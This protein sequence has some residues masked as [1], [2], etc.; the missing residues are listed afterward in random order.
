MLSAEKLYDQIKAEHNRGSYVE[1]AD[2]AKMGVEVAPEDARLWEFL[3]IACHALRNFPK[4][5]AA[6]EMASLLAPLAPAAEVALAGC[7][8]VAK[9]H[10][11]ARSMYLHLATR[12]NVPDSLLRLIAGGLGRLGE[13]IWALDVHR[14]WAVAHPHDENALYAVT[15]YMGLVGYPAELILPITDRTFRLAPSRI[16]NRVALALVHQQV[17]NYDQAYELVTAVDTQQLVRGCCPPKLYRLSN[18]FALRGD[19]SRHEACIA[20]LAELGVSLDKHE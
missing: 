8:F 15:H 9:K 5:T 11:L 13:A 3:G 10:D 7:Y 1:A 12:P 2:L 6:L 4:A 14:R 19:T 20:R 17:G 18:L 16:R